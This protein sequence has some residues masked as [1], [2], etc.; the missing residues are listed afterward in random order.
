MASISEYP[1]R[2]PRPWAQAG[3]RVN[4]GEA[5]TISIRIMHRPAAW[6]LT[7]GEDYYTG[8]H[9]ELWWAVHI[10]VVSQRQGQSHHCAYFVGDTEHAS[11]WDK[12]TGPGQLLPGTIDQH[13]EDDEAGRPESA[14]EGTWE[15][16][17]CGGLPLAPNIGDTI[18]IEVPTDPRA[19][20]TIRVGDQPPAQRIQNPVSDYRVILAVL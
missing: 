8:T 12:I 1:A 2:Y 9:D 19:V 11:W 20:I 6:R 16:S 4:P 13:A 5:A 7:S 17:I 15:N 18:T 14:M 3:E 10:G